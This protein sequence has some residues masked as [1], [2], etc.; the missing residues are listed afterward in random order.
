MSRIRSVIAAAAIGGLTIATPSSSAHADLLPRHGGPSEQGV[1]ETLCEARSGSFH[2]NTYGGVNLLC[3]ATRYIG[4][5]GAERVECDRRG[6]TW[7]TTPIYDG[8]GSWGCMAV[9]G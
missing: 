7:W 1:L 8:R 9:A 2:V 6:G 4:D 3:S 5:W